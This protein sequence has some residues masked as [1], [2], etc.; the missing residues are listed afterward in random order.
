M[1]ENSS[2]ATLDLFVTDS[3]GL[4]QLTVLVLLILTKLDMYTVRLRNESLHLFS[5]VLFSDLDT[6]YNNYQKKESKKR[7]KVLPNPI[8]VTKIAPTQDR[9]IP[10]FKVPTIQ[11]K[12]LKGNVFIEGVN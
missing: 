5:G 3:Q 10:F 1:T 6:W 12:T 8:D 7:P 2:W 9:K 11:G 4:E